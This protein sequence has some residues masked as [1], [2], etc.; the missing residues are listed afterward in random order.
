ML[1]KYVPFGLRWYI[2]L[3]KHPK[4]RIF[5]KILNSEIEKIKKLLNKYN[6]KLT[7]MIM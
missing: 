7:I 1:Q 5:K 3:I 2:W 4:I 6:H